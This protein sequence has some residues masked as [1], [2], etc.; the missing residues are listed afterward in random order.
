MSSW[1]KLFRLLTGQV[2]RLYGRQRNSTRLQ[3]S[4]T[5]KRYRPPTS[6]RSLTGNMKAIVPGQVPQGMDTPTNRLARA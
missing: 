1:Q 6:C 2:S 4:I 5:P 3:G